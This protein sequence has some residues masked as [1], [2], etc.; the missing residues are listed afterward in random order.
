MKKQ[1]LLLSFLCF[2]LLLQAQKSDL[3]LHLETGKTYQTKSVSLGTIN[4]ELMGNKMTID[5]EITAA[6]NFN[7]QS[8]TAETIDMEVRYSDMLMQIKAAQVNMKVS[9]DSLDSSN[10]LSGMLVKM[11][12]QPFYLKIN[13]K[14]EVLEVR[15]MDKLMNSM[16]EAMA[17]IPA[18]QRAQLQKQMEDSYGEDALKNNL[19]NMLTIFPAEPVAP[20]DSWTM[21]S[22]INSGMML[23]LNTTYTLKGE[24]GSCYI[25]A[26]TGTMITPENAPA[27][28]AGGMKMDFVMNGSFES[29]L[30]IDKK[31]GWLVAGTSTQNIDG[32][33]KIEASEQL[34]NGM[35]IPM[36]IV[37]SSSFTGK[38]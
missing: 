9:S 18:M 10:P 13:H 24:E 1:V 20:G 15:D 32:H 11:T 26:S 12:E 3:S 35:E 21:Q 37:N 36:K 16:I 7:I 27:I 19:A 23:L 8:Q 22:T 33:A 29:E 28:D 14:G 34:P 25:I 5:M 2:A 31:S 6:I 4:Q 30:K 17:D 38:Q